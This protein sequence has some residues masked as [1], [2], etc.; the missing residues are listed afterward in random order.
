MNWRVLSSI[1][2]ATLLV[3]LARGEII[4]TKVLGT[5]YPGI[6]KHPAALTELDN[7]DLYLTFYGGDDDHDR[8]LRLRARRRL[9]PREALWPRDVLDDHGLAELFL[10]TSGGETRDEFV[11]LGD[12]LFTLGVFGFDAGTDLGLRE[13][14]FVVAAGVQNDALIINVG[15][16]RADFV[17]EVAVVRDDDQTAVVFQ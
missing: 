11:Q 6:Y 15:G 2:F 13:H 1:F 7:G 5:E 8:R 14:H 9:M 3:P 10:K 16:V 12:F 4:H 17:Q